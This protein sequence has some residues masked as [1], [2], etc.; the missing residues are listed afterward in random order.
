MAHPSI[1]FFLRIYSNSWLQFTFL[2]T[3]SQ[4]IYIRSTSLLPPPPPPTQSNSPSPLLFLSP[5]SLAQHNV[6]RCG[7][8]MPQLLSPLKY[9][10]HLH[11]PGLSDFSDVGRNLSELSVTSSVDSGFKGSGHSFRLHAPGSPGSPVRCK[12]VEW[13][14]VC[15][16]TARD[17][18]PFNTWYWLLIRRLHFGISLGKTAHEFPCTHSF[19]WLLSISDWL[20]VY[21][22]S[23]TVNN[24]T[25][26]LFF[27]IFI[28]VF[29]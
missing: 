27:A 18:D 9:L 17:F 15:T 23:K 13:P 20:P 29:S 26:W 28:S 5:L 10:S 11:V 22:R 1:D 21:I 4:S 25:C 16:S 14:C 7:S 2:S 3:T 24:V 12:C 8:N 19:T 6:S